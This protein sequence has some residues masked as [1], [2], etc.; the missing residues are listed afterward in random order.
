MK[1]AHWLF[2]LFCFGDALRIQDYVAIAGLNLE[3]AQ[4]RL[5]QS[6]EGAILKSS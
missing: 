3:Q 1:L 6:I 5:T 2:P 4:Q